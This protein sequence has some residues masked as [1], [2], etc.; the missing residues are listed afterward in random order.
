M[1]HLNL[2]ILFH[3]DF[4]TSGTFKD[5][6]KNR[7]KL[8]LFETDRI[9]RINKTRDFF[10]HDKQLLQ[11]NSTS[12]S[13]FSSHLM[14]FFSQS[15][16]TVF[17]CVFKLELISFELFESNRELRFWNSSSQ[18]EKKTEGEMKLWKYFK[19]D[20]RFGTLIL[21]FN[22]DDVWDILIELFRRGV[23]TLGSPKYV[24]LQYSSDNIEWSSA[25]L[26]VVW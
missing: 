20:N 14:E 23:S 21:W 19:V 2:S 4:I 13:H 1:Q 24:R 6:R 8:F 16:Q 18:I 7:K 5:K 17:F 25:W 10:T 15:S 12:N 3:V 9:S 11:N 26:Y 22:Y